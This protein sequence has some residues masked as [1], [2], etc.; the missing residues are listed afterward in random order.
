MS[1]G[2]IHTF[3]NY[4]TVAL[5]VLGII[6]EMLG[7]RNKNE[8]ATAYGWNCLR[9]GFLFALISLFTGFAAEKVDT[10]APEAATAAMFHKV[11]SIVFSFFLVVLVVFRMLF[12]KKIFH[13]EEGAFH[14]GIYIT[15]QAASLVL[16][17]ITLFL[18]VRMVRVYGVGVAP[19][20]K[21]NQL[22]PTPP[23]VAPG[24]KVDTTEYLQ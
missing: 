8:S 20:T 23:P 2:E 21:M 7:R 15:L 11:I 18:G 10:A 9:L 12:N 4:F 6:F 14:R 16:I 22:P 1:I 24:I 17:L 5:V 3:T 19:V 13:P